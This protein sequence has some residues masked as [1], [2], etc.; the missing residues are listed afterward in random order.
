MEKIGDV[1]KKIISKKWQVQEAREINDIEAVWYKIVDT[2]M[3]EHTYVVSAKDKTITVMVDSRCYLS[4]IKR[5]EK[6]ILSKL[7]KY[8]WKE[9]QKIECRIG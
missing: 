5:R 4:E 3:G 7:Q 9:I 8:G 1:I 2:K 6:E